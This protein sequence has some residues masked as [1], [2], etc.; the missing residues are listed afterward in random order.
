MELINQIV[1]FLKQLFDWWFLVMPWEQAVFVRAG[2]K[3][4]ILNDGIYFKIP[5]IDKVFIQTRRMRM[6]DVPMQTVTTK[7]G[8][9]ITIRSAIGYQIKDIFKLYNTISHPEINLS[10]LVMGAV[11][12]YIVSRDLTDISVSGV[13]EEIRKEFDKMDYGL[14]DM[15]FRITTWAEVK[16]YRLIQDASWMNESLI[17]I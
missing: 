9:P 15:T 11:A 7:D 14:S 6:I 12:N 5:F 1:A 13:E 16:T 2:K 4:K 8:K 17:M 10:S 3:T